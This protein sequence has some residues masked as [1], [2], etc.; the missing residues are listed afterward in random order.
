MCGKEWFEKITVN[1]SKPSIAQQIILYLYTHKSVEKPENIPHEDG[2]TTSAITEN[3]GGSSAGVVKALNNLSKANG[4]TDAI[5]PVIKI[6]PKHGKGRLPGSPP[7]YYSLT[8]YGESEA[9]AL[10][11]DLDFDINMKMDED[12]RTQRG[13]YKS[14]VGVCTHLEALGIR[15]NVLDKKM[16]IIHLI[17]HGHFDI[18]TGTEAQLIKVLNVVPQE[19]PYPIKV[20][21]EVAGDLGLLAKV[22]KGMVAEMVGIDNF[23]IQ[24]LGDYE[25]RGQVRTIGEQHSVLV[26]RIKPE[27]PDVIR[28]RYEANYTEN[29]Y[30]GWIDITM[31]GEGARETGLSVSSYADDPWDAAEMRNLSLIIDIMEKMALEVLKRG[32]EEHT[33]NKSIG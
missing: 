10:I 5:L 25:Y 1:K 2:R 4:I 22:I 15:I 33:D 32:C 28:Y 17:E 27:L 19:L 6:R 21:E 18:E 26:K 8:R 12:I 31:H 16:V 23:E 24:R 7:M 9:L 14:L 30:S 20:V 11:S 13:D 29:T 3:V